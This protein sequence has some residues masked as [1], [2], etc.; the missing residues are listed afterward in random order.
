MLESK[1]CLKLLSA[2]YIK[3]LIKGL[4]LTDGIW[5]PGTNTDGI[6]CCSLLLRDFSQELTMMSLFY[7]SLGSSF[8]M[9]LSLALFSD[10]FIVKVIFSYASAALTTV[11]LE[12]CDFR[13]LRSLKLSIDFFLSW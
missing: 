13:S 11:C 9:F 8:K 5:V 10:E 6:F 4:S 7:W 2:W 1:D 3:G 12:L